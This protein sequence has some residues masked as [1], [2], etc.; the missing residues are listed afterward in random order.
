MVVFWIQQ[1]SISNMSSCITL[2]ISGWAHTAEIPQII[3]NNE[4]GLEWSRNTVSVL[5]EPWEG[6]MLDVVG[7]DQ[8]SKLTEA[9]VWIPGEPKDL[10]LVARRTTRQNPRL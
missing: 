2:T 8:L 6:A 9:N 5:G 10:H 7:L 4:T 1:R 3:C